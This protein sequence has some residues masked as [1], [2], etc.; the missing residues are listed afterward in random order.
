[1]ETI[2]ERIDSGTL[3]HLEGASDRLEETEV[4]EVSITTDE[5]VV[6]EPFSEVPELGRFVLTRGQD[7]VAGGIVA[8]RS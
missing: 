4:A 2:A 5:K 7:V 8:D 1:L 6:V 3:Q